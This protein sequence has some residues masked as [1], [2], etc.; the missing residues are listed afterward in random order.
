[1]SECHHCET[2]PD[3]PFR[4]QY[5]DAVFCEDH[6]LPEAHD[7]DGVRFLS[8]PGKRFESKFSDEIVR[9][10]EEIR[11]PEPIEPEYTVG[12]RPDPEYD[13][14]PDTELTAE[15]KARNM[16]IE[17]DREKPSLY[18]PNSGLIGWI[19]GLIKR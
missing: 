18:D 12:T 7:C 4:C 3:F 15:A 14:S 5:C 11:A 6:R 8:D 16:E 1:M 9:T 13:G 10:N 17:L 2:N 19:K